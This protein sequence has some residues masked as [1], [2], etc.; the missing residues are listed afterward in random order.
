M[1]VKKIFLDYY[2]QLG[3]IRLFL[4]A[5]SKLADFGDKRT[6]LIHSHFAQLSGGKKLV[7]KND[8][9]LSGQHEIWNPCSIFPLVKDVVLLYLLLMGGKNYPAFRLEN[10]LVPYVY[11]FLKVTSNLD[12][13]RHILDLSNVAQEGND[14]NFL[15]SLLGSTVC[16]SSHCN[17]IEGIML[18]RFLLDLIFQLQSTKVNASDITITGLEQLQRQ[19]M[20]IPFLSPPNMEWPAYLGD[21]PKSNFG[22]LKRAKNKDKVDILTDSMISGVSKDYGNCIDLPE[23]RGILFRIPKNTKLH[24]VFTRNLQ[25]SYFRRTVSSF[26]REFAKQD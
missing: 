11:Y 4:N 16:L 5:H 20:K 6:A 23:L 3:Q 19:E 15:E 13:R 8:G 24:L 26:A 1:D 9:C 17:G 10:T 2:G 18:D 7:L 22:N 14:G 25:N 21:I 12:H